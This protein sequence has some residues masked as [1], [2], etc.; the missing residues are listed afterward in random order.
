MSLYSLDFLRRASL[1]KEYLR[2]SLKGKYRDTASMWVCESRSR[3][4]FLSN[5][6][7]KMSKTCYALPKKQ[8]QTHKQQSINS[9]RWTYQYWLISKT[10]IPQPW[11]DSGC[12]LEDLPRVMTNKDGWWGIVK[13]ICA[14]G[15]GM[16]WLHI[17][18]YCCTFC[19]RWYN[20]IQY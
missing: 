17:Y 18:Q 19:F 1:N 2:K 11:M 3:V 7:S 14:V 9:Y 13:E 8:R 5:L 10:Y 6:L 4:G 16:P 12:H 20:I 15:I